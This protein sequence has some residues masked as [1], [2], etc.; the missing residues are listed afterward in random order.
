MKEWKNWLKDERTKVLED[1]WDFNE[2]KIVCKCGSFNVE[3]NGEGET[4]SGYYPGEAYHHGN[5]LAKCHDCG[6]AMRIKLDYDWEFTKEN[7]KVPEDEF[8]K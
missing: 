4:E 6:N 3:I 8:K 1:K 2:F 5:I 7:P